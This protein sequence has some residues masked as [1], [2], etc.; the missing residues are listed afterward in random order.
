MAW[1]IRNAAA[2]LVRPT[3]NDV[4]FFIVGNASGL[5]SFG[6]TWIIQFFPPTR[7]PQFLPILAIFGLFAEMLYPDR[8]LV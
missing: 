5:V 3:T 6:R 7:S 1:L 2:A 4:P 8:F